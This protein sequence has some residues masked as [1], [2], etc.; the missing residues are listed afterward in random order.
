MR[1]MKSI[2]LS[3]LVCAASLVCA[4][5][6]TIEKTPATAALVVQYATAKVIEAGTSPGERA[7][8]AARIKAIAT[9]AKSWL[10]GDAVTLDLL[11]QVA[12]ERIAKLDLSPADLLLANGL[13]QVVVTELQA[14]VGQGVLSPELKLT[15]SQVLA[16][17]AGAADL[18]AVHLAPIGDAA[19]A[20]T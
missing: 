4:S 17:V 5:C 7:T 18:Y 9:D 14:K 11:Q 15:V 10:D 19:L 8:R 1:L 12:Q 20:G 3:A 13:L 2:V 16:W 6:E